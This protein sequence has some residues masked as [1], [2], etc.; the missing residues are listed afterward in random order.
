[1]AAAYEIRLSTD[2]AVRLDVLGRGQWASFQTTRVVNGVGSLDLVLPLGAVDD[3]LL[4]RDYLI[5]ILR[6][7]DGGPPALLHDQAYLIQR[8]AIDSAAR[9]VTVG[10][11]DLNDLLRRRIV[12]Y[13]AGSSETARTDAADDLCKTIVREN[14]ASTASD[15][16]GA[17]DRGLP[18]N[19]LAVAADL[20]AAPT[21][22]KAYAWRTPVLELLRDIAEASRE[23]GT[24]LA[25]DLIAIAGQPPEFRT[26]TGQRGIDRRATMPALSEATG[27]LT[28]VQLVYD[29]SAEVNVAY[30]GG[31]G[32]Q[33]DR[34]VQTAS[35]AARV[36]TS[37]YA[38]SEA[39]VYSQATTD[40]EA[41]ADARGAVSAGRSRV[42]FAAELTPSLGV[43]YGR[44]V[45]FGDY[46][47][48]EAF[49][50]VFACRLDAVTVGVDSNG[51]ETIGA[52]LRAEEAL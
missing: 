19:A 35:D 24:Y 10:A 50:R 14:I 25:F 22:S 27:T 26:Y 45:A 5:T 6:S 44:D 49:G 12:A 40:A 17:T 39:F 13:Y 29:Y 4:R 3:A 33:T 46:V 30:A 1:M 2:R 47:M 8:V 28:N 38:R 37:V 21:I 20:G 52:A 36:G 16:A 7:I 41:L 11:V 15:Y 48:A 43:Q 32:E 9:T 51:L 42:T 18:M 23:A 31:Q 34:I